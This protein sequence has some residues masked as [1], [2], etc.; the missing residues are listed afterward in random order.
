MGNL[1]QLISKH[2]NRRGIKVVILIYFSHN[3][4]NSTRIIKILINIQESFC[5][6]CPTPLN[7]LRIMIRAGT[8]SGRPSHIKIIKTQLTTKG[9]AAVR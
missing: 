6:Y 5:D 2:P 3:L 1:G 4:I 7:I 9:L 8:I